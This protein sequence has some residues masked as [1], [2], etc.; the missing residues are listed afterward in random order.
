MK[1]YLLFILLCFICIMPVD[2]ITNEDVQNKLNILTDKVETL[3]N[4]LFLKTHPVGSIYVTT[5]SSEST[6]AQMNALYGGTW[7]AYGSGKTLVG[8]DTSNSNFN[9]VNKTGGST[10]QSIT[11]TTS[12]LP[13]H[14]HTVTAK[15]SVSST[16]TGNSVTT[17]SSGSHSHTFAMKSAYSEASGYCSCYGVSGMGYVNSFYVTGGS[18][19]SSSTSSHTH[20]LTATGSVTSTFTGSS[21]TTSSV[22]SS[23][24]ISVSTLQPY[25]TVYM[26]KRVA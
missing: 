24:P 19:T 22:G 13:S 9:T 6:A 2:A 18:T 7:E 26:W 5:N 14:S 16:F 4:S 25:T 12:N 8:I 17:S 21:A 20:T 11:L 3:Q 23:T 10:S 15:G 1:K